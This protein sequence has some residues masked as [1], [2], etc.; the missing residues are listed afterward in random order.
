MLE[1]YGLTIGPDKCEFS[2]AS[3]KFY[4][5][6]FCKEG[7][8]PDPEKVSTLRACEAPS[9]KSELRSFLGMTNFSAPFIENYTRKRQICVNYCMIT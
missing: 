6:I 9:S 3:I 8:M 7:I 2:K 1:Y 5:L 4:G